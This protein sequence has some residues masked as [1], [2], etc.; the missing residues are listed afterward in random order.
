VVQESQKIYGKNQVFLSGWSLGGLV[1]TAFLQEN[2]DKAAGAVLYAPGV[3]LALAD[4]NLSILRGVNSENLVH[5]KNL[6]KQLRKDPSFFRFPPPCLAIAL[7]RGL[8]QLDF[9]KYKTKTLLFTAGQDYFVSNSRVEGFYLD[10]SEYN[11][12]ELKL[13]RYADSYH[14]LENDLDSD[15]VIKKTVEFLNM[16]FSLDQF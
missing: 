6:A 7:F 12:S 1:T 16:S 8:S 4:G 9:K 3:S 10:A 11:R 13:N 5:D 2:P 15:S 14:D